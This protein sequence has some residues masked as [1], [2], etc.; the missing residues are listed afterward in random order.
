MSG[1]TPRNDAAMRLTVDSINKETRLDIWVAR[2]LPDLSRSRIK[3]L[4][5]S[6]LI[7][8]DG[9]KT[10]PHMKVAQD[11]VVDVSIPEPVP[12]DVLP[13]NIAL[14]VIYEDEQII[15]INK[16][17]GIV[18]HP[19]A[20]RQNGTLVNAL[21][22]HCNDL[23]GIGDELRP[24]I[25][26]RL[27]KDTSGGLVVAKT[28][29]AMR[30]LTAQFKKGLVHKQ[31]IAIV[32]GVPNPEQGVIKTLIARSRADRK[33]MTAL[34]SEQAG[35]RGR[36]A[37]TKYCAIENYGDA[38]L[39]RLYPKTGRTHQIRVHMKYLGHHVLG[40]KQ[41]RSRRRNPDIP[42]IIQRQMLHAETL[43]FNHPVKV[44]PMTFNAPWPGDIE[45]VVSAFRSRQKNQ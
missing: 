13:Q 44:E 3:K 6:G 38:S 26:H 30:S 32:A 2:K 28:E 4:I 34:D 23:T 29:A 21:L 5:N 33:K 43:S 7:F 39:V 35:S 45:D 24:G 8:V 22:Y 36:K 42:E 25:V 16:Q 20:G 11:M 37:E 10:S 31:Y 15:V 18:V 9:I 17:P 27:D 12:V 40:D 41:Y 19:G 14:D 1:K